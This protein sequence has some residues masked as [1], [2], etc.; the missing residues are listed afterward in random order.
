M[1]EE[2][3]SKIKVLWKDV[4]EL[5]MPYKSRLILVVIAVKL[6]QVTFAIK[7]IAP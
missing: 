1:T 6:I 3:F 5:I 4:A 2:E 7:I